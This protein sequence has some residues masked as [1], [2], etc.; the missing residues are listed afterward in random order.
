MDR[1]KL[2]K[3]KSARV[4]FADSAE[5]NVYSGNHPVECIIVLKTRA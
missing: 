4:H 3:H 2:L 1:L 5:Q